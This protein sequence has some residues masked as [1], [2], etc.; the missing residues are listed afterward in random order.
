MPTMQ[1]PLQ[2][3]A[4]LLVALADEARLAVALRAQCV[5]IEQNVVQLCHSAP[6][7]HASATCHTR[8][9]VSSWHVFLEEKIWLAAHV[10]DSRFE[11]R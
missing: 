9:S 11:S 3:V 7:D 2:V 8:T 10:L 4:E 1:Y 5:H 6:V